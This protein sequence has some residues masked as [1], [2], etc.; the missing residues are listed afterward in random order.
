MDD[1]LIKP[2]SEM[3]DHQRRFYA[4]Q[5][6][7]SL[8]VSENTRREY[9]YR[10]KLFLRFSKDNWSIETFRGYKRFLEDKRGYSVFTKSKYLAVAKVFLKE[11]ARLGIIPVDITI[12]TK[13]FKRSRGH[14]KEG[15]EKKDILS[16]AGYL[17]SLPDGKQSL[18]LK[19]M[20]Y[21]FAHQGLRC[22]EISR[23]DVEDLN[24]KNGTALI[25]G[26]GRDGKQVVYLEPITR[27]AL[28]NYVQFVN[29]KTGPL[30]YSF[31][32]R[33]GDRLTV[34]SIQR[35]FTGIFKPLNIGK[36]CHGFRH[37]YITSLLQ[38]GLD[39]RDTQKFS[40]HSDLSTVTI[41]DDEQ[42][43]REKTKDVFPIFTR[44]YDV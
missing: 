24:L 33:S 31:S 5:V 42:D 30:F 2:T 32:N 34:Y 35:L 10:I 1:K 9:R 17:K 21:L 23:L 8:D 11:L 27:E 36:S 14:V 38:G 20:F 7:N 25:H 22:I 15:L 37:F 19:A 41:Y 16:I 43:L 3:T 12:N 4:E 18:R 40:R 28:K 6:I 29:I 44:L 26:K 39:I 13:D